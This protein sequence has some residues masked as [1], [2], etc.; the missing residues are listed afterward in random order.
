MRKLFAIV[1]IATVA[2]FVLPASPVG[3]HNAKLR[4]GS[5]EGSGAGWFRLRSHYGIGCKKARDVAQRWE[6]KCVWKSNC[7]GEPD[8]INGIEPG[9]R[10]THRK[11][12]YETV[13]V[14]CTAN[15]GPGVIHF[16]W[17]S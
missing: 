8:E 13:R 1:L 4:C 3:A 2:S 17:G 6:N 15:K 11:V 10:C 12:G 16:K 14:R 5:K 9:F 7:P